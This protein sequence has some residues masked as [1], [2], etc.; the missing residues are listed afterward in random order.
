MFRSLMRRRGVGWFTSRRP[1][2][3][4]SQGLVLWPAVA[5]REEGD[6]ITVA[7]TFAKETTGAAIAGR[8]GQG[9]ARVCSLIRRRL[10]LIRRRLVPVGQLNF[11]K[12]FKEG[13]GMALSTMQDRSCGR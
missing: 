7:T 8:A 1:A 5:R 13:D 11:T 2:D 4:R 12:V 3:G 6:D 9:V 10:P